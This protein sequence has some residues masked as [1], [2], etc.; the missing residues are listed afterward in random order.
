[1][2]TGLYK[3]QKMIVKC[4]CN[5][6]VDLALQTTS[7]TAVPITHLTQLCKGRKAEG[8]NAA[9]NNRE[10]DQGDPHHVRFLILTHSTKQLSHLST[11]RHVHSSGN[12]R[13]Q[14]AVVYI[15]WKTMENLSWSVITKSK[16]N[17]RK[18]E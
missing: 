12:G 14:V 16:F 4:F 8:R 1:M 2:T 15:Q 18:L 6:S 7:A 5:E 17:L 10:L 13:L 9:G 11:M 3:H